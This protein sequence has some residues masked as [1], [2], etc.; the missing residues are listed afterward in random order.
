MKW[1]QILMPMLLVIISFD[2]SAK[3]D[4]IL[5]RNELIDGI[6][7]D[8]YANMWWQ[9]AVSMPNSDSPVRDR[10]G[11]KC[12]INQIGPVWFLAGGYG[13]SKIK[14][15]C[16]IPSDKYVFFPVINML[17]YPPPSNSK[18][19]CE[20]AKKGAALNNQHLISFKVTI[21]DKQ[22]V[23]PVFYRH[24]SRKCFD[25][26]ARKSDNKQHIKLYPSATDGYWVMLE[27]L[28]PG[29][30]KIAFKAEYNREDEAFGKMFQD[31]EYTI[32]VYDSRQSK[33]G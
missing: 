13:S 7:Q 30:H 20:S 27:P 33:G 3:D 28:A 1:I 21:D 22:L 5:K 14:R 4:G 12:H 15:N 6:R 2:A 17:Y 25:L 18:L 11:N 19:T 24:A 23:N 31:I 10:I 16:S 26:F 32:E 29:R 8:D 9:W